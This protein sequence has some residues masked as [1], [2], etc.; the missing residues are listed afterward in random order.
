MLCAPA[1]SLR[2]LVRYYHV[3]SG[4]PGQVMIPASPYPMLTFMLSGGS[5]VHGPG[6]VTTLYTGPLLSGPQSTAIAAHW[7]PGTRFVSAICAPASF[8]TLFG[9]DLA[10]LRD[11]SVPIDMVAP[12]LHSATLAHMLHGA[13]SPRAAVAC[14]EGWL[15]N[16]AR[17]REMRLLGG[18]ALPGAMLFAP[19][20]EIAR[21][22]GLSVRQLERKHRTAYGL[23]LG[24]NRRMARYVTALGMLIRQPGQRGILTGV[25]NLAGY[26]D[27]AHMIHDFRQILG[28]APGALLSDTGSGEVDVLRLLRYDAGET[29]LVAAPADMLT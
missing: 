28:I 15:L 7:L 11:R 26:H 13:V 24:E 1:P 19:A 29:S 4:T 20:S 6:A 21:Q 2:A 16:L 5:V 17:Q 12:H 8:G 3:E 9:V 14:M 23:T 18:F 25:A 27:Q 10:E 22:V